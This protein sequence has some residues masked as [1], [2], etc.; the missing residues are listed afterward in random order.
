[1]VR[2]RLLSALVLTLAVF[3]TGAA[4]SGSAPASAATRQQIAATVLAQLN[5]ERKAHHLKP[6]KMNAKLVLSAHRHNLTMAQV[7]TLTHQAPGEAFFGKRIRKA[8]FAYSYAGEN[9]GENSDA[10]TRGAQTLETMMYTEKPPQDGHRRNILDTHFTYVGIDVVIDA[11]GR[12]WLTED[13]ARP[14]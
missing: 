1:V 14:L 8:G 10:S 13:F 4:I 5:G 2:V 9:I 7:Q 11:T 3:A 12:L 6:L